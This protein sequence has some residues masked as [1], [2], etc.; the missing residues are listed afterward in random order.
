MSTN[1]KFMSR[2]LPGWVWVFL[3]IHGLLVVANV[4]T[5]AMTRWF[6]FS[7]MSVFRLSDEA[8]VPT[9]WSSI[10][11]FLVGLVFSAMAFCLM[12]RRNWRT[13]GI[14]FP[15]AI[16][17]FLSLDETASLHERVGK[18]WEAWGMTGLRTGTWVAICVPLFLVV[19]VMAVV[20]IWPQLKSHRSAMVKMGSGIALL[21]ASAVGVELLANFFGDN[22]IGV[23]ICVVIEELGEM[24]STTLILWGALQ[25]AAEKNIRIAFATPPNPIFVVDRRQA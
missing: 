22:T 18:V 21:L 7:P 3:G 15:A 13:W 14:C 16:F 9:W 20:A 19:L 5:F 10:Q 1:F 2:L 11:W 23:N 24:C 6:G 12:E 17:F 4:V 8:N 25:W